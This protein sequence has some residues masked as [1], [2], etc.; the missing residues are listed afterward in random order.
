MIKRS[1]DRDPLRKQV[2]LTRQQKENVKHHFTSKELWETIKP[3]GFRG[4]KIDY[5]VWLKNE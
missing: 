1:F 5:L 2:R 3:P 4:N